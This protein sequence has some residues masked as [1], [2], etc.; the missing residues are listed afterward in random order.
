MQSQLAKPVSYLHYSTS[1][2]KFHLCKRKTHSKYLNWSVTGWIVF[3]RCSIVHRQPFQ[4]AFKDFVRQEFRLESYMTSPVGHQL[5]VLESLLAH[6]GDDALTERRALLSGFCPRLQHNPG[7]KVRRSQNEGVLTC[8]SW[9]LFKKIT[10]VLTK[11]QDSS[12][13]KSMF[14]NVNFA[15]L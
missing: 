9:N 13:E 6:L 10:G 11:K 4:A 15:E 2:R 8:V 14:L 3:F 7:W 12:S 5:D 1:F